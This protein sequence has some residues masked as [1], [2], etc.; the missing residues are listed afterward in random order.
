MSKTYLTPEDLSDRWSLPLKTLSQWRWYRKG[1][2]FVKM[3]KRIR[4]TIKGVE[5]FENQV[6]ETNTCYEKNNICPNFNFR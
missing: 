2:P 6:V 1:P 4:Y 3:G 5:A